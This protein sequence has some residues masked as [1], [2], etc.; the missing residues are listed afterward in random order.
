M[1]TTGT[2]LAVTMA[3]LA[4]TCSRCGGDDS[5]GVIKKGQKLGVVLK[6]L[7]DAGAA[8]EEQHLAV[9]W[10]KGVSGRIFYIERPGRPGKPLE[11]VATRGTNAAPTEYVVTSLSV[12][13]SFEHDAK[14]PKK[15]RKNRRNPVD[16]VKID[17]LKPEKPK[18]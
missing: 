7:E 13:D 2:L 8:C 10:P 12:Y 16:E 14:S 17:S 6:S 5:I 3:F 1:P 4:V 11:I 18:S 9:A 15:F